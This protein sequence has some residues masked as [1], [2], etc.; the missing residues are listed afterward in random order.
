MLKLTQIMYNNLK[1][2]IF[3]KL[4]KALFFGFFLCE[5]FEL[6]VDKHIKDDGEYKIDKPDDTGFNNYVCVDVNVF[7]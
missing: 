7:D 5:I 1:G 4:L 3:I 2:Y 6:L